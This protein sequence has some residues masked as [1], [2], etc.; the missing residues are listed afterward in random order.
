V[1]RR[2]TSLSH[3]TVRLFRLVNRATNRAVA[4]FD[5]S[6]EQAHVLMALWEMGPVTIGVLQRELAL[7]SATLTGAIDRMEKQGLVRRIPSP[8]DRR[9]SVSEPRVP[10]ATKATILG[11][12]DRSDHDCFAAIT[13]AERATLLRLLTACA[14]GLTANTSAG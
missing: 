3:A 5:L 7:S 2:S 8:D 11:A 9:A 1:D 13:A 12:V 4:A 10:A 6:G 14:A